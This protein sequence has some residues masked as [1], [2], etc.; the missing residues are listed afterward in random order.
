MGRRKS[1]GDGY[2]EEKTKAAEVKSIEIDRKYAIVEEEEE[3]EA[4]EE[5][6][7]TFFRAPSPSAAVALSLQDRGRRRKSGGVGRESASQTA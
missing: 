2:L 4:P 1:P 3:E 6:S 5:Q 7:V